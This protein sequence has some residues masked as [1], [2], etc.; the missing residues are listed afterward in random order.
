MTFSP[1]HALG[2]R[3]ESRIRVKAIGMAQR[4]GHLLVCE[5][6]GD[7]NDVKGW[8]PPGG[9]VEFGETAEGALKREIQEELGIECVISG[10][11]T[12]CE[13]IYEHEGVKGHEIVF[14][15]P[16]TFDDPKVYKNRRFLFSES[17][18]AAHYAEWVAIERFRSGAANL[19][20]NAILPL[21]VGK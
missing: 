19:F 12:I 1:K 21:L 10:A 6:L 13:N 14:A 4:D 15:F 2:W 8:V 20:P 18:G 16:I 7:A 17:D 9:G 5:V 11:P 3:P